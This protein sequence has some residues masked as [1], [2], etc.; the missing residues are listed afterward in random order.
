MIRNNILYLAIATFA[1]STFTGCQAEEENMASGEEVTLSFSPSVKG[2]NEESLTRAVG[3]TFF[4]TKDKISVE[5]TTS[6]NSTALPSM[7][8]TYDDKGVFI[9]NFSFNLDNTYITKLVAKW[10]TDKV[11]KDDGIV[12]D[13]RDDKA[14][15]QADRL[16]AETTDVNIMPTAEP[17][18]LIFSHEQSR[19]SFRLAGQNANGLNIQSIILELQYPDPDNNGN[20]TPGAFWAHCPGGE[21]AELILV[22]GTTVAGTNNGGSLVVVDGR[23]M[24][25][26]AKVGN[27]TT[28]Y[29]GGIWVNSDVN[30][31]L[32]AGTD[33]VVTLTPEG[34]NLIANITIGGFGQNEGYVG[35]PI[36]MPTF[37][38]TGVYEIKNTV[39]LVTL[40]R[41][42]AGGFIAGQ[43]AATWKGYSY[44]ISAT[45][46]DNGKLYFIPITADDALKAKFTDADGNAI[47]TVKDS[48]G[49]DYSLFA[50]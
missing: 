40:S 27:E 18:P 31:T 36:Q 5:I 33:Y 23:F 11:R 46:T 22:P 4:K 12:L 47:T 6:R 15:L 10:P 9:G 26:Q 20:S 3:N 42:L 8:Y 44:K 32:K 19:F 30:I 39:Q 41:L 35:I 24:I 43:D 38:S 1:L 34:Y 2:M 50:N 29:T 17:I 21:T 16:K 25:G 49:N 45:M 13:Q 14:F 28:Q 7:D 37:V 48:Q